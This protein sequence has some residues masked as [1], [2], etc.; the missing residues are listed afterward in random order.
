MEY[1]LSVAEAPKIMIFISAHFYQVLTM[2]ASFV[3]NFTSSQCSTGRR[4]ID[5]YRYV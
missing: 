1:Y 4:R 3:C 5:W 2:T